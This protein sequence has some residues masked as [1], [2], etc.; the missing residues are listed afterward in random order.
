[1]RKIYLLYGLLIF[2]A[3]SCAKP[4]DPEEKIVKKPAG[5]YLSEILTS[6]SSSNSEDGLKLFEFIYDDN[7]YLK[8]INTYIPETGQLKIHND[9]FYNTD[10]LPDHI[11][12]NYVGSYAMVDQRFTYED[13][14]PVMMEG[15]RIEFSKTKLVARTGFKVDELN[16]TVEIYPY[17]LQDSILVQRPFYQI[18]FYNSSGNLIKFH[19]NIGQ[20][21]S[22]ETMDDYE[23]DHMISPFANLDIF[24]YN[25]GSAYFSL[26]E[27]FSENN[28]V[29][30]S[31]YVYANG[32]SSP[33]P[34]FDTIIYKY[35]GA[36]PIESAEYN[37]V[38]NL[39]LKLKSRYFFKYVDLK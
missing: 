15:Y 37:S 28:V 22:S 11:E 24:Y 14:Q 2:I 12:I 6:L 3:W 27:Y 20:G 32:I 34:N 5:R 31:N 10:G 25:I 7:H 33:K 21:A 38:P 17:D 39:P 9:F 35:D 30:H 13:K 1:M 29:R 36:Y 18:Y 23:Y 4:E 8:T 16:H 19:Y 26:G